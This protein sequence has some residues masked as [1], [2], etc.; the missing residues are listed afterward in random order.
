MTW[1]DILIW[2]P[3]RIKI[4]TKTSFILDGWN[5]TFMF[6]HQNVNRLRPNPNNIIWR[7]IFYSK[8]EHTEQTPV[9]FKTCLLA[10][11]IDFKLILYLRKSKQLPSD[12]FNAIRGHI[13]IVKNG[14]G[15]SYLPRL[16]HLLKLTK[17]I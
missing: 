11:K 6:N 4:W 12:A 10:H 3:K 5:R 14:H 1:S 7:H 2:G 15:G 13:L 9:C 16:F 8:F 17:L